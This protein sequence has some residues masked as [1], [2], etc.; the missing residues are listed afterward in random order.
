MNKIKIL[1]LITIP[2]LAFG[3]YYVF[4]IRKDNNAVTIAVAESEVSTLKALPQSPAQQ[5]AGIKPFETKD[6]VKMFDYESF[7]RNKAN[8]GK[9][10]LSVTLEL[11]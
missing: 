11:E 3:V 8:H 2:L 6:G 1:F 5:K 9:T 4:A 7:D 10:P